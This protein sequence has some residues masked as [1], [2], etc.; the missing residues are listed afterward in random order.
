MNIES[1][2]GSPTFNV[3]TE[4]H[5]IIPWLYPL[6]LSPCMHLCAKDVE[7]VG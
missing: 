7:H 5:D 1:P 2:F 3:C 4:L 6:K